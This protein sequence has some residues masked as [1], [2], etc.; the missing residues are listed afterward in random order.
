MIYVELHKICSCE[1]NTTH[2]PQVIGKYETIE[3]GQGIGIWKISLDEPEMTNFNNIFAE[4]K[5]WIFNLLVVENNSL[6]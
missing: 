6:Q 5:Q 3:A 1:Q 4:N 2:G